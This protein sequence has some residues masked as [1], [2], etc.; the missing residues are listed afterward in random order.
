MNNNESTHSL[1]FLMSLPEASIVL[2]LPED[3]SE[4]TSLSP[5]QTEFD[6]SSTTLFAQQPTTD[7]TILQI[8]ATSICKINLFQR[9]DEEQ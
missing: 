1:Y 7:G 4:V 5:D 2:L 9:Y 6:T 8:T 3:L